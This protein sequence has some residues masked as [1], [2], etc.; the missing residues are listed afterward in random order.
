MSTE[1][2]ICQK[3][4]K[5]CD[6]NTM[7][8]QYL[9]EESPKI[10]KDC[11]N[12][13]DRIKNFEKLIQKSIE[14]AENNP[15]SNI[16]L[17]RKQFNRTRENGGF[18]TWERNQILTEYDTGYLLAATTTL[19][20]YYWMW[21]DASLKIRYTSCCIGYSDLDDVTEV[22]DFC[23]GLSKLVYKEP[24]RLNSLINESLK[25]NKEDRLI[26]EIN[27]QMI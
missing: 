25:R 24:D 1:E 15:D 22:P 5:P 3:D 20:D 14:E 26:T 16:H 27:I 9:T 7:F 4:G 17:I 6:P 10:K 19:E 21:I 2:I 18:I 23:S 12:C 8:C 13:P 11:L